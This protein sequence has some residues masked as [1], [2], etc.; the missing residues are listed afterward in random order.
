MSDLINAGVI[1]Q[2]AQNKFS[3]IGPKGEK[4]FNYDL[5]GQ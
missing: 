3:A 4:H 5:G 2:N 1:Q